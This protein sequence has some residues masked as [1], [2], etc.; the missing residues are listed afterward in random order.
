MRLMAIMCLVFCAMGLS[1][2]FPA[3][4]KVASGDVEVRLTKSSFWNLAGI[5]YK[6][7]EVCRSQ[8]AISGT[9]LNFERKGWCG[10]GHKDSGLSEQIENVKFLLDGTE[11][12]PVEGTVKSTRFEMLKR[13]RLYSA[14]V[15]YHLYIVGNSIIEC[16][17]VECPEKVGNATIYHAMH[18][19]AKQFA[20]YIYQGRKDE[21][22]ESE[23][24]NEKRTSEFKKYPLCFA[25]FSPEWACSWLT[26]VHTPAN[27]A[28]ADGFDITNR[29]VDRKLYYVP[30]RGG[31]I[32]SGWKT[33]SIVGTTIFDSA[34]LENFT[35]KTPEVQ[36]ELKK[37]IDELA[38]LK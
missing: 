25:S 26:L 23:F 6:G 16:N 2:E 5:W 15:E 9:T 35:Q 32:R 3:E 34:S 12:T 27:F 11:W 1:Q 37:L 13:S 24:S 30:V 20:N 38:P 18:P 29:L 36:A 17:K 33:A 22:L 21:K 14:I 10:S 28:T 4:F 31:L 7:K 19:W 8:G